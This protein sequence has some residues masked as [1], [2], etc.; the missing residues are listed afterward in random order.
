MRKKIFF[1][2]LLLFFMVFAFVSV[3]C[4]AVP[5]LINYQGKLTDTSGVP[6]NGSY[7]ITFRIY[8]ALSAGSMLWEETQQVVIDKG[9]F[10]VLLGSVV[11]LNLAFDAPYF[12]EIKVGAEVMSPRQQ[13]A[14]SA[15]AITADN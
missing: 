4:A 15:Y 3:S 2:V 11:S 5:R 13:I 8:D 14:A 6:L 1:S 10:G 7:A 12:L 9:I